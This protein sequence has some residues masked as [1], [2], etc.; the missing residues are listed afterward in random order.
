MKY[1]PLAPNPKLKSR[2]E[3]TLVALDSLMECVIAIPVKL[4]DYGGSKEAADAASA[5][6][7]EC[8]DRIL[9]VGTYLEDVV[10]HLTL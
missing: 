7:A 4:E 1:L 2:Y 9:Q 8:M 3:A 10:Q 6:K 5:K